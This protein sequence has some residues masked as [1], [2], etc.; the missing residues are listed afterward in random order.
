MRRGHPGIGGWRNEH[1]RHFRPRNG[2]PPLFRPNRNYHLPDSSRFPSPN[3]RPTRGM[4]YNNRPPFSNTPRDNSDWNKHRTDNRHQSQFHTQE[5]NHTHSMRSVYPTLNRQRHEISDHSKQFT[6]KKYYDNSHKHQ[7]LVNSMGD[8]DHR[9]SQFLSE[10]P[11]D[12]YGISPWGNALESKK[13]YFENRNINKTFRHVYNESRKL[14]LEYTGHRPPSSD[15]YGGNASSTIDISN[16][17]SRSVDDT[18]DIVRKRLQNRNDTDQISE[19]DRTDNHDIGDR[20]THTMSNAYPNEQHNQPMKKRIQKHRLNVEANCDKMKSKIVHE[21]F[22]MDKDKIHKLMDN[23][24]SSSKF[25]Y[26]LS[27]LITESQNSLNRH[28]RS[29]AEKSLCSSEDFIHNDNNTIYEDTFMKQMQG[30]LDPQDTVLLEDIKPLVLAEL[31]KVLQLDDFEQPFQMSSGQTNYQFMDTGDGYYSDCSYNNFSEG[32]PPHLESSNKN[33]DDNF[34]IIYPSPEKPSPLFKYKGINSSY[35]NCEASNK[36]DI[37]NLPLSSERRPSRRSIDAK[38]NDEVEKLPPLFDTTDQ[39]SDEDDPFAELDQQYHVAVDHNF[40]DTYNISSPQNSQ[41]INK[42]PNVKKEISSPI[43]IS[44]NIKETDQTLS[45]E[46]KHMSEAPLDIQCQIKEEQSQSPPIKNY[47]SQDDY[48]MH[49]NK[50]SVNTDS[51]NK[52]DHIEPD[53]TQDLSKPA[54]PLHLKTR[55]RTIEQKPSHR[56]EKRKKSEFSSTETN[57]QNLNKNTILDVNDCSSKEVENCNDGTKS[58]LNLF[59]SKSNSNKEK[60]NDT[61]NISTND[62]NTDKFVKRR[63]SDSKSEKEEKSKRHRS[64]SSSHSS[65]SPKHNLNHNSQTNKCESKTKL[66]PIDMFLEQ[67]KKPIKHQAHR[68]TA[69]TSNIPM[70]TIKQKLPAISFN[71]KVTKKHVSTQV[72][73]KLPAKQTQTLSIKTVSSFTQTEINKVI[74]ECVQTEPVISEKSVTK[75]N[76]AFER[77]KEID[78]EIQVLLQEK[79]KLYNSLEAGTPCPSTIQALGMTVLNVSPDLNTNEVNDDDSLCEDTIVNDFTSI[80]VEE[81]EQI[82]LETVNQNNFDKKSRTKKVIKT[83]RA[84]SSSPTTQQN[85][86]KAKTPNISLIEQ[87]I[88]DDRP[89]EDIISLDAL[90]STP[91]KKDKR[92]RKQP[93]KKRGAAKTTNVSDYKIKECSVLLTRYDLSKYFKQKPADLPVIPEILDNISV[94]NFHESQS[95]MEEITLTA[96]ELQFDMLD[97]SED[98]IIGDNCEVKSTDDKYLERTEVPINEEIILDNSHLTESQQSDINQDS[99]CRMYD[100]SADENLRRDSITVSGHADAVLAIECIDNNFIA[101]C[102]D[103]NVYYFNG[104]GQLLST[105]RGSNL[106]VTCLTIVKE[107]YGTTVYTGSLDSRIRYFDLE[108]GLE[109]GPETG[110]VLQFECK[111]NMLIPVSTVK[112]ADQSILALRAMK[113]GARKVLLVAARSEDVTIKDAQTGLLLRTLEGP[114]MTVYTILYEDGKIYCGTSSH[115]VHVFDYVSG[116]HVGVHEGGKG[117][118]PQPLAQLRGPSLMLLSLAVLGT[119]IIAGYKDRSLY[120]WK[121]PLNILQE[122]IL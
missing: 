48:S 75:A 14:P 85:I 12:G 106:A 62:K 5:K 19:E 44:S 107:K 31:S 98:I 27:S 22:K 84:S 23:P 20:M 32:L 82:V 67:P 59:F 3:Q 15:H 113:E 117:A 94:D 49:S 93:K 37:E 7:Y 64:L 72:V 24:S 39:F 102:L 60:L 110:F 35:D 51:L 34:E 54:S 47:T 42:S 99:I 78:L 68:N 41:N 112:F 118:S 122:M 92:K 4:F 18:V 91:A 40:I 96:N 21:L 97:V 103:G 53:P 45:N 26:A 116:S 76:D 115:Q 114:K 101:A 29:V 73:K 52:N 46:K 30:I 108:T 80:P 86:K 90:E 58:V 69:V 6:D 28:L 8:I 89:L 9:Q 70:I 119:K 36:P 57:K 65:M 55:K 87:I 74:C 13:N 79:F 63:S 38:C 77:M 1:Q 111:N 16:S 71:K 104:D 2:G 43:H 88:T 11:Q 83:E 105:L 81:L 120:I 109:K 56:K 100:Y 17:F 121:I 95:I 25:E 61:N 66:Q 10:E 33:N 50:S